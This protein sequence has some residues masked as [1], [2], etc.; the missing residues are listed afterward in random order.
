MEYAQ[1]KPE[2][3]TVDADA[4]QYREAGVTDDRLFNGGELVAEL[5]ATAG[6][7]YKVPFGQQPDHLRPRR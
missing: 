5:G 3:I 7:A 6:F 4:S 2:F 1:L